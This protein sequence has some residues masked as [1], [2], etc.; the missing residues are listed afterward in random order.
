MAAYLYILATVVLTAYGQLILKWRVGELGGLPTGAVEKTEALLRFSV[1]PWMLTV[2]AAAFLAGLAWMVAVSQLE[3]SRAYP[4]VGLTFAVVLIA[5]VVF[6]GEA[7]TAGKVLGT[8][9]IV[10]G[11]IVGARL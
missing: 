1:T 5:S 2:Y 3:L 8:G 7:L 9:L 10:L 4:F 11:I 6:F